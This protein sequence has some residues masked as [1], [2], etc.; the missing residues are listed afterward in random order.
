MK[1]PWHK[2]EEL[3]AKRVNTIQM[4]ITNACNLRC[5][6]CFARNAMG[7]SKKNISMS[8]YKSAIEY[9]VKKNGERVNL[10]GGEPLLHPNL[11]EFIKINKDNGLKTTIYTN[12]NFLNNY[13]KEDFKEAKLRVSLYC[14]SGSVKSLDNLVK[15]DMPLDFCFMVS[16]KT[17]VNELLDSANQIEKDYNTKVFFISSIRE[18]DNPRKEFFEDTKITMPVLEYKALVHDFLD[19]YKGNLDIHVSKRGVFESTKFLNGNKCKFV[20]YFI[21]G[22]IIQCP[23]DVVNLKFQED[24]EFDKRH[25]QQNNACLMSK[26][27][28]RRK[29]RK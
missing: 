8:E 14:K 11:L 9:F 29:K 15:T 12:G 23:Y 19:K 25:C 6:G 13:K 22:K 1:F 20:N 10:L 24:Y 26:V 2:Y 16:R 3:E 28:Y 21:G 18:L 7:E 4:F 17:H 5:E 27:I